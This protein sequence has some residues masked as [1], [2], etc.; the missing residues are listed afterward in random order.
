MAPPG[1]AADVVGLLQDLWALDHALQTLSK[2]MLLRH[3]VT[4]PQRLLVRVVGQ[5]SGCSP[6]QAARLLH[7]HPA[8]VTR[9]AARLAEAGYLE[10]RADRRDARRIRLVLTPRGEQ[11]DAL[12]RGTV[13][14]A[15]R[16]VLEA[17][18]PGRAREARA[19]LAALAARLAGR[20]PRGRGRAG[21]ARVS[22]RP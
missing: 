14:T 5:R 18:P 12:R 20:A 10:R 3:G 6:G 16:E 17:S 9:L 2:R 22:G 4:G 7:L 15:V 11:I 13:E 8:T 1:A 21:P 19:L